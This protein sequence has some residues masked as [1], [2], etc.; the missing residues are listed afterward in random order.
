MKVKLPPPQPAPLNLETPVHLETP[1]VV[2]AW[3]LHM[4]LSADPQRQRQVLNLGAG[5]AYAA[6]LTIGRVENS[7]PSL[8]VED[9]TLSRRHVT[10]SPEGVRGVNVQDL[11]SSNGT[12]VDGQRID[13]ALA[14][15]GSVV[16]AGANVLVVVWHAGKGQVA[17]MRLCDRRHELLDI[18]DVLVPIK[19]PSGAL[20]PWRT[21]LQEDTAELLL[22]YA[23][24]DDKTEFVDT[25]QH[26]RRRYAGVPLNPQA[27]PARMQPGQTG[28]QGAVTLDLRP[29]T[30]A[31]KPRGA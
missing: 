19:H 23:W 1:A 20:S 7:Q 22:L 16:R 24:P 27:L 4:V 31:I 28:R 30:G 9:T 6:G 11:S 17:P 14:A 21:L 8:Q 12:F 3:R 2:G 15:H 5:E 13:T 29:P 26:L 18:A 25:L 10:L